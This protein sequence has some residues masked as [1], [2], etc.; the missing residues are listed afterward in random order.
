[1]V[2]SGIYKILNIINNKYYIGRSHNIIGRWNEHRYLL[3]HNKHYNKKLQNSWNKYKEHNFFLF[4]IEECDEN[5]I[6]N[7]EQNYIDNEIGYYNLSSSAFGLGKGDCF[8][9]E[10]GRIRLSERWKGENNPNFGKHLSEDVINKL[11]EK[12]IGRYDGEKHPEYGKKHS[13]ERCEKRS[14]SLK[15]RTVWN[16]GKKGLQI[17]WNKGLTK[18]TD[19]RVKKCSQP[20]KKR[21]EGIKKGWETRRRKQNGNII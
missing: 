1:M 13:K 15:G 2:I 19:E 18:E 16:K 10:D 7:V 14:K 5:N 21:S 12:M 3:R 11:K 8:L 20:S 6:I 9:T 4:I 17:A